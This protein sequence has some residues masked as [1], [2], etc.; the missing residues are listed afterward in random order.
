VDTYQQQFDALAD[1]TRRAILARL[2]NGPMPVGE[3][4]TEF[5]MSRPAISQHLR[6]LKDAKLVSDSP[7][8]NRRLYAI[9]IE[10]F[11][12]LRQYFDRFWE[13]AL[14]AFQARVNER[15]HEEE[16]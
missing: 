3:I 9:N 5:P 4:A 2:V 13:E 12:A 6:I 8:G 16:V 14:A 1:A 10:G 7:Q 15:A 11:R